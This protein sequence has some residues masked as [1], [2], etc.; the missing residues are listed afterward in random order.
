[1]IATTPILIV[2][3]LLLALVTIV[4]I[5]GAALL[6]I[7]LVLILAIAFVA[8]AVRGAAASRGGRRVEEREPGESVGEALSPPETESRDTVA[9][10]RERTQ[11]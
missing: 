10:S 11:G 5:P 8:M 6:A 3:V 9:A 1:M 7:P 2:I 4:A